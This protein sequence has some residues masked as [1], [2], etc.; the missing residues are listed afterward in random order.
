MKANKE[1]SDFTAFNKTSKAG[2]QLNGVCPERVLTA[3]W[4]VHGSLET[5]ERNLLIGSTANKISAEQPGLAHQ[6]THKHC[7]RIA[8]HSYYYYDET[9]VHYWIS[10]ELQYRPIIIKKDGGTAV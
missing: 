6:T 3:A 4:W 8:R 5:G 7:F 2:I 1:M 10:W 9:Q